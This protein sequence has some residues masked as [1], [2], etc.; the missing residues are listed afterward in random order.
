MVE[1]IEDH[2]AY[3]CACG[4]VHFNLLKSGLIECI[5]CHARFG[6]WGLASNIG[7]QLRE[8]LEEACD[9]VEALAGRDNSCD[10]SP[11]EELQQWRALLTPNDQGK[12]T[13]KSASF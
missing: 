3:V 6:S 2:I 10:P 7:V 12:R 8:A 13:G 4:S 1:N 11:V 5:N 9:T